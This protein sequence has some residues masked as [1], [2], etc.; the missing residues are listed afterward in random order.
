MYIHF[1]YLKI[2]VLLFLDCITICILNLSIDIKNLFI[3]WC[4]SVCVYLYQ[5]GSSLNKITLLLSKLFL[6][7]NKKV[8]VWCSNLNYVWNPHVCNLRWSLNLL[9]VIMG[10]SHFLALIFLWNFEKNCN[11]INCVIFKECVHFFTE[12]FVLW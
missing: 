10:P 3:V 4:A 1:V 9:D 2:F 12:N 6:I 5:S 8:T 11:S 7:S